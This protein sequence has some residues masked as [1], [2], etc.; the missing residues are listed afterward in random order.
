MDTIVA[1]GIQ[2]TIIDTQ[3]HKPIGDVV[4][5]VTSPALV[6]EL[7]TVSDGGGNYGFSALPAGEYL[8]RTEADGHHAYSRGR[9][10]AKPDAVTRLNIE[11]LPT[12]LSG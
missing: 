6:G 2:G 1:P 11:L 7:T 9:I 10:N 5:T 12:T 3:S 4:V 8:V